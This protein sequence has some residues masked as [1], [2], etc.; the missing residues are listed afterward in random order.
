LVRRRRGRRYFGY[1]GVVKIMAALRKEVVVKHKL[2]LHARPAAA[3]VK[4]ARKFEADVILEKNGERVN[5][6]SIMGVMMLAVARGETVY[7]EAEG[8]DGAK[9]CEQLSAFLE[10]GSVA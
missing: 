1:L 4:L 3:F 2:G 10:D 8:K 5:A 6:K 9:A 7:L